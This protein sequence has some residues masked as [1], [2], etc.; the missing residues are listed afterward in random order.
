LLAS[1]FTSLIV[2]ASVFS[3]SPR[4]RSSPVRP[5]SAIATACRSFA[6]SNPM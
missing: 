6:V 1:F 2:A 4:K 3:I 5:S